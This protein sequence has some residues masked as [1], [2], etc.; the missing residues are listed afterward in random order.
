ML[1]EGSLP[2]PPSAAVCS[3][4]SGSPIMCGGIKKEPVCKLAC[5][6]HGHSS[7]QQIMEHAGVLAYTFVVWKI[8]FQRGL[9]VWLKMS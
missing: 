7:C 1:T 3:V 9:T 6:R 8:T 2:V 4:G 5:R